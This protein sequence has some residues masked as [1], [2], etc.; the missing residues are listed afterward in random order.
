MCFVPHAS[1]CRLLPSHPFPSFSFSLSCMTV[2]A[3]CS[4]LIFQVT[5]WLSLS[6]LFAVC[7]V[8]HAN[9]CRLYRGSCFMRLPLCT[10]VSSSIGVAYFQAGQQSTG[11]NVWVCVLL[12][13][14]FRSCSLKFMTTIVSICL[15]VCLGLL[16]L[17]VYPIKITL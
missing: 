15:T 6:H 11:E 5:F 14:N 10:C 4:I 12:A 8:W 13:P 9:F 1:E 7:F 16:P 3:C 17:S 2:A